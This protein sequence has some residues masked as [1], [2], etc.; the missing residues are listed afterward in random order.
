MF[1][2][3]GREIRCSC[4]RIVKVGKRSVVYSWFFEGLKSCDGNYW[5]VFWSV[6][7]VNVFGIGFV[8]VLVFR[9]IE[10]GE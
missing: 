3:V 4:W 7:L 8:F 1:L 10:V 2:F 9:L 6:G 5:V